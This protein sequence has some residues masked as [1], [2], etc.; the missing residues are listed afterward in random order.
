MKTAENVDDKH[1]MKFPSPKKHENM[2]DKLEMKFSSMKKAKNVD[3]KLENKFS[4]TKKPEI[5][6]ENCFY[7]G[8]TSDKIRMSNFSNLLSC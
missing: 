2:D 1:E 7:S 3:G 5:M 4:S 8:K 6:D